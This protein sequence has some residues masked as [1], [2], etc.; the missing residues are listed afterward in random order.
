M[1][2]ATAKVGVKKPSAAKSKAKAAAG[3]GL[4]V[5]SD[6]AEA[7]LQAGSAS[8]SGSS[9]QASSGASAAPAPVGPWY[10]FGLGGALLAQSAIA[11]AFVVALAYAAAGYVLWILASFM[12]WLFWPS[13]CTFTYEPCSNGHH[14]G[15]CC[16]GPCGSSS[17]SGSSGCCGSGSSSSG[18][19]SGSC[20]GSGSSSTGGG[21]TV[22]GKGASAGVLAPLAGL[23]FAGWLRVAPG[24]LDALTAH[25]P[26]GERFTNDVFRVGAVRLC[27]GCFTTYPVFLLVSAW[28]AFSALAPGG[29]GLLAIGLPLAA[30]QGISS[31][32]WA[33]V[34]AVK[35]AVKASLGLGL[36]LCV[37][38][39]LTSG[40]PRLAEAGALFLLLAAAWL[41][42][43]PR[44]RR[45]RVWQP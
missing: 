13:T 41:S 45:M 8:Q 20:C 22:G 23:G 42:A 7:K 26:P 38:G 9:G 14:P 31:L 36:A 34:R 16:G 43:L 3:A 15:P 28:L 33:R 2:K 10:T 29:A 37:H 6:M 5:A 21:A 12:A 32:G 30:V 40:W 19:S 18:S 25:H 17:S 44:A 4:D 39:V 27:V 24:R 11:F 1:A 35:V